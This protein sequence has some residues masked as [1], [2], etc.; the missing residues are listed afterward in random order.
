MRYALSTLLLSVLFVF[1]TAACDDKKKDDKKEDKKDGPLALKS[2]TLCDHVKELGYGSLTDEQ[3]CIMRLDG[4]QIQ[5]GDDDWKTHGKCI[6]GASS[7]DA[8]EACLKAADEA[9]LAKAK[10]AGG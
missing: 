1:T 2:P 6:Q 3:G 10:A 9:S 7:T 8:V 5:L 4:L